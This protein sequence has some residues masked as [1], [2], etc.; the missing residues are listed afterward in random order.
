MAYMLTINL[1]SYP[2]IDRFCGEDECEK[3]RK[4]TNVGKRKTNFLLC[5]PK[6]RN[7]FVLKF[8]F[9]F[10]SLAANIMCFSL[11]QQNN[12]S[13]LSIFIIHFIFFFATIGKIN[14]SRKQFDI[15]LPFGEMQNEK[16]RLLILISQQVSC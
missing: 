5:H 7:E 9:S 6:M 3:A 15:E 1:L 13:F 12:F 11:S 8:N 16:C 4:R 2:I 10:D 14:I